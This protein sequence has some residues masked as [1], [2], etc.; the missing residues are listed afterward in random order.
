MT[1]IVMFQYCGY[2]MAR[3]PEAGEKSTPL[4][5]AWLLLFSPTLRI[6]CAVELGDAS[7]G[8]GIL[9]PIYVTSVHV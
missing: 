1:V 5:C 3:D 8:D 4:A 7:A 2:Y 9:V 6:S